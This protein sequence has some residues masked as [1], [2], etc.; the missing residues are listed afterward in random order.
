MSVG[1]SDLNVEVDARS[2]SRINN[3]CPKVTGGSTCQSNKEEGRN[4]HDN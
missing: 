4:G 2:S 1:I 3:V